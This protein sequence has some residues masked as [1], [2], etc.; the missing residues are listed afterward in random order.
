MINSY[1][2]YLTMK[3]LDSVS[4]FLIVILGMLA[5]QPQTCA[6]GTTYALGYPGFPFIMYINISSSCDRD[7]N[8]CS[9]Y[10][11]P[12]ECSTNTSAASPTFGTGASYGPAAT[13]SGNFARNPV[14]DAAPLGIS[15]CNSCSLSS[16]GMPV[17]QIS[18]PYV[19]LRLTD[20]PLGYQPARG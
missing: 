20:A 14:A 15:Q 18:E 6:Q 9:D 1:N 8:V 3:K 17:W 4:S 10:H 12:P 7:T 16:P 2:L 11:D 13:G 19:N 5:L